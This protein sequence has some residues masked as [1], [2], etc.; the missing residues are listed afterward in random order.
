MNQ[1]D[2]EMQRRIEALL[3]SDLEKLEVPA[4]LQPDA[5]VDILKDA[6]NQTENSN[7]IR[8]PH[9]DRTASVRR[10]LAMVA[11]IALIVT[12]AF[13]YR[14]QSV[15]QINHASS[16]NSPLIKNAKNA[17]ELDQAV[18]DILNNKD[19]ATSATGIVAPDPKKPGAETAPA[20]TVKRGENVISPLLD[21][22]LKLL[23]GFVAVPSE[24]LS[25]G[26]SA[27]VNPTDTT[28]ADIVKSSGNYL[29]VVTPGINPATGMPIEQIR[30]ISAA[31]ADQMQ[32]AATVTLTDGSS[33]DADEECFDLFVSGNRMIALLHRYAYTLTENAA[34]DHTQTVAVYYD[35]SDP[36][37]PVRLCAAAQ[38]GSYV[39]SDLRGGKLRL[40]T[41]KALNNLSAG[42]NGDLPQLT[43]DGN[44]FRPQAEDV[45][46]AINDPEAS[47]LFISETALASPFKPDSVLAVLGCG[48]Q[49]QAAENAFYVT[50]SFVQAAGEN[51][52]QVRTALYRFV[53]TDRAVSFTGAFVLQGRLIAAPAALGGKL[54][55]AACQDGSSVLYCLNDSME[56]VDS[57]QVQPGGQPA[58][59]AW[60]GASRCYFINEKKI[61]VIDLTDPAHLKQSGS[62]ETP[63]NV[64]TAYEI[65][66][67][68]MIGFYATK[69]GETVLTPIDLSDPDAP[70]FGT[71]Y[72]LS[73]AQI[74][75]DAAG[76]PRVTVIPERALFG[77]PVI[78]QN[79]ASGAEVSSYLLFTVSDG[80]I[81][82]KGTYNHA[83]NYLGDAAVYGAVIGDAFYTISGEKICAF[84]LTGSRLIG[85]VTL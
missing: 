17:E 42:E 75:T 26:S 64:Q 16:G 45:C 59:R 53:L 40:V 36:T 61:A 44:V 57:L 60:F 5:I 9:T 29:Y 30:I 22:G 35:I 32:V 79:E 78:T 39:F 62:V 74:L 1:K 84:E 47:Y 31:P 14:G 4:R 58:D 65:S 52:G 85:S 15:Q 48:S 83:R 82:P 43:V 50:R 7:L 55:A 28:A 21:A 68:Q 69:T 77:L 8:L 54:Y 72:Q 19:Q 71:P 11:M 33:G 6:D 10:A 38:E 25:A 66:P 49:V 13:L 2:Q 27:T 76:S 23:E 41:C 56:C 73:G 70:A 46:M 51:D 81:K 12:G 24:S 80:A 67:T 37:S 63:A 20:P 3:H 34:V 18:R